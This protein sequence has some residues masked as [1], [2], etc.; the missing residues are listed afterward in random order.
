VTVVGAAAAAVA[1]PETLPLRFQVGARTLAAVPRRLV[2]VSLS[3]DDVLAGRVPTLPPLAADD[4]GYFVTSL[5]VDRIA[6]LCPPG[7]I[8]GVRQG[9]RRYWIDL[10]AGEAAWSSALSANARSALKRKAKK[11]A[12]MPGFAITRHRTGDEVAAFHPLARAVSATTYQERLLDCGLPA[13]PVEL[14]ALAAAGRVR[15]WLLWLDGAPVAYLACTAR[16]A[17]LSYDHV[18]H[19]P[20]HAGLSPGSVLIAEALRDLFADGAFARFDFTEGEGQHKRGLATG[21]VDCVDLLLLR[22]TVVNRATLRALRAF[23]AGMALAKRAAA[24]PSLARLAK[25]VRR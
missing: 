6:D 11:L 16:G 25:R 20:A 18:G 14:V 23:D 12:A 24:N 22:A 9:Y 7:M 19:D 4:D 8:A 21:G 3:L 10:I 5:P 13:D 17:T 15:A 1:M 2:R